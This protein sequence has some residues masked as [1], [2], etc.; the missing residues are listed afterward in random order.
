MILGC[1]SD[2]GVGPLIFFNGTVD[3][4]LYLKLLKKTVKP[5]L[6]D[7]QRN[8]LHN[9]VFMDDIAPIHRELIFEDFL[10]N[11]S[12]EHPDWPAFSPVLDPI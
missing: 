7:L 12:V 5:F 10:N 1:I 2:F 4:N 6:R 8:V 9:A 11:L 3:S